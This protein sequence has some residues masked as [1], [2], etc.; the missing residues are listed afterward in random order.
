MKLKGVIVHSGS[1]DVGHYYAIVPNNAANGWL[2]LDDARTTVFP[3][4]GFESEC[5]G[6]TWTAEEWGGFGSS[7]NAYVL[8]YEK[9]LKNEIR[10]FDEKTEETRCIKY[11]EV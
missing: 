2:K 8:I 9:V 4:S 6:G 1:A 5:F 7:K 3:I 10:L 11:D